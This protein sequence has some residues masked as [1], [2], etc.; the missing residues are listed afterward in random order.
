[1]EWSEG[2]GGKIDREKERKKERYI[3]REGE[4]VII[5]KTRVCE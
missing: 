4:H 2:V 5:M 1:V 3:D